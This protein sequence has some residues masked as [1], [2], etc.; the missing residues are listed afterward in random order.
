M[1]VVYVGM[2]H[3]EAERERKR[4]TDYKAGGTVT[5]NWPGVGQMD[6]RAG[7]VKKML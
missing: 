6:S 7:Q 5:R 2:R 4:K 3:K 1:N